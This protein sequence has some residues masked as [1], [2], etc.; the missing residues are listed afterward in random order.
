MEGPIRDGE[1]LSNIVYTVAD[2]TNLQ[3]TTVHT[4]CIV[5]YLMTMQVKQALNDLKYQVGF[6]DESPQLMDGDKG[7]RKHRDDFEVLVS[8]LVLGTNGNPWKL[9]ITMMEG[10]AA[11]AEEYM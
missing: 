9:L 8:S 10:V 2:V 11:V 6:H 1:T 5:R 7:I 4:Q 3:H